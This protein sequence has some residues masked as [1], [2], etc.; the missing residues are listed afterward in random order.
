MG[1][2]RPPSSGGVELLASVQYLP[3]T[4]QTYSTTSTTLADLDADNLVITFSA[5]ASGAVL[6]YLTAQLVGP[7]SQSYYWGL[8]SGGSAVAGSAIIM[9]FNVALAFRQTGMVKITGLTPGQSYTWK[10]AHAVTGG[11]GNTYIGGPNIAASNSG[12]GIMEVWA[13]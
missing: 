6:V 11:T 4:E 12:P 3:A 2:I 8:R 5:P 1:A 9:R 10:W 13:A 7:A